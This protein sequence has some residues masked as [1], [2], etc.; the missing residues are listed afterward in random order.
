M[1]KHLFIIAFGLANIVH[2]QLITFQYQAY[3]VFSCSG[4]DYFSLEIL[5]A[6]NFEYTGIGVGDNR[7]TVDLENKIL[8]NDY[9]V[10]ENYSGTLVYDSIKNYIRINGV[11]TFSASRYDPRSKKNY[12]EH[13][14]ID[15]NSLSAQ[16]NEPYFISYWYNEDGTVSG[17][18]V[19]RDVVLL[20]NDIESNIRN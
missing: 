10:R 4:K 14:V 12:T 2:A 20:T 18:I 5:K 8:K 6:P 3:T 16:E 15:E 13:F 9:Y 11:V 19:N 7:I 17:T 1:K